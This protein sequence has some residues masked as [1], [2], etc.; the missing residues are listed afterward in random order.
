M[1]LIIF[2]A[3]ILIV[4]Q[5]C[6][7]QVYQELS[8]IFPEISGGISF[9]QPHSNIHVYTNTDGYGTSD[10]WDWFNS[11]SFVT[12]GYHSFAT[13]SPISGY[14]IRNVT[15]NFHLFHMYGNDTSGIYPIFDTIS[16]QYEPLCMIEHIDYGS[17]LENNDINTPILHP[18]EVILSE[19]T[20]GWV[21]YDITNWVLDDINQNRLLNQFRIRFEN[22]SDWDIYMDGITFDDDGDYT[23]YLLYIFDADSTSIEDEILAPTNVLSCYP[24]PFK[25]KVLI[26]YKFSSATSPRFDIYNIKGQHIKAFQCNRGFSGC[27]VW[28]GINDSG[29]NVTPGVYY[30]RLLSD[31]GV[32]T[33]KLLYLN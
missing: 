10:G 2:I 5:L 23:P 4:N 21:S 22:D 15:A 14:H 26:N 6:F 29:I 8:Y 30:V 25:D 28:D 17:S 33:S 32:Y 11:F 19:Y 24:N 7:A 31:K 27:I 20:T 12:H 1:K 13:I 18:S 9:N 16:G 3:L